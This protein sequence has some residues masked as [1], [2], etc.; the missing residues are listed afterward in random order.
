MTEA[1]P[2]LHCVIRAAISAW[3]ELHGDPGPYQVNVGEVITACVRAAADFV[4]MP[5]EEAKVEAL[6]GHARAQMEAAFRYL[7]RGEAQSAGADAARV[8]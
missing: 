6:R 7:E 2:C 1:P 4:F 8:H 5:A 3:A